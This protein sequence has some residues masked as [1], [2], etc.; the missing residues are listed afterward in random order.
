MPMP[1]CFSPTPMYVTQTI[2]ERNNG[3]A[4]RAVAGIWKNGTM[5]GRLQR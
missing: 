2:S 4:I 3:I 1:W 5:P